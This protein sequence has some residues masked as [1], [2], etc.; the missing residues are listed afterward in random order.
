MTADII[1]GAFIGDSQ[2]VVYFVKKKEQ[3]VK[4]NNSE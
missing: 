3:Y 1:I 4:K 2:W